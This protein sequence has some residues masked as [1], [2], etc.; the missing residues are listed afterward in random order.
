METNLIDFSEREP[1]PIHPHIVIDGEHMTIEQAKEILLKTDTFFMGRGGSPDEALDNSLLSAIGITTP[2]REWKGTG[3][4][5]S[6]KY[7]TNKYIA[8]SHVFGI[9]GWCHPDGTV[10]YSENI[11]IAPTW[12]DIYNECAT[13]A[14]A[15]PFLNMRLWLF[16][17]G[18]GEDEFL[19][20]EQKKNCLG[21]FEISGGDVRLLA[22]EEFIAADDERC[23]HIGLQERTNRFVDEKKSIFGESADIK[24]L[25][26][27]MYGASEHFFNAEEFKRFFVLS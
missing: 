13:L 26:N 22:E 2:H 20:K 15:F 14:E 16:N 19:S 8:T 6:L 18:I 12:E 9:R 24:M 11:G 5:L 25:G 17:F 23:K 21:G 27:N 3:K 7:L 1:L 10:F 4:T